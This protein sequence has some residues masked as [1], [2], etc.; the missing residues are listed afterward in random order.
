MQMLSN[1]LGYFLV[2][3]F[4]LSQKTFHQLSDDVVAVGSASAVATEQQLPFF[5]VATYEGFSCVQ[6]IV[7]SEAKRS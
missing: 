4:S 5:L 7:K 6:Y 1:I 3:H 2:I